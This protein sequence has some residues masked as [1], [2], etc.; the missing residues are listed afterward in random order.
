M[1]WFKAIL[2]GVFAT[3]I[4]ADMSQAQEP[5][6]ALRVGVGLDRPPYVVIASGRG[7]DIDLVTETLS[8]AGFRLEAVHAPS[9]RLYL[10][11]RAGQLDAF[12]ATN[13]QSGVE[14]FYSDSYIQYH[15]VAVSLERRQLDP[16]G[17][18]D[19]GDHSVVA[20]QRARQLLGAEF[21]LM[22]ERNAR[23]LE[24]AQTVQL[25]LMLYAG[26]VDYIITDERIFRARNHGLRGEADITQPVRVHRLFK[27]SNYSVAFA[28]EHHR[29]QFNQAL[30]Q[31]RSSGEYTRILHRYGD[32]LDTATAGLPAVQD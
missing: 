21:Q 12:A 1:I 9:E 20:F 32:P 18:A 11:F 5:Q 24:L 2:G 16:K 14:A 22:S 8:L 17:I 4:C 7:L 28:D 27:P 6:P 31:L 25:N 15:N 13:R 29:D 26:R 10:M 30:E 3:L 19:L 23:Y